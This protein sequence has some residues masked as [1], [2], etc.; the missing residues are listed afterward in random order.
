[1]L[2]QIL[3]Q[4]KDQNIKWDGYEYENIGIFSVKYGKPTLFISKYD[5]GYVFTIDF[6]HSHV[7]ICEYNGE[8][9][10]SN[11]NKE[12]DSMVGG[13]SISWLEELY[14]SV[15]GSWPSGLWHRTANAEIV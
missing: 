3:L 11:F 8:L 9:I 4:T 10:Q 14:N 6:G 7:V 5:G 2:T 15:L 12:I 1:M 13:L